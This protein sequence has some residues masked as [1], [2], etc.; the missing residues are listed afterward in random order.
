MYDEKDSHNDLNIH[1]VKMYDGNFTCGFGALLEQKT[2]IM[3]FNDN[4]FRNFDSQ[5][6]SILMWMFPKSGKSKKTQTIF[7]IIS[8]EDGFGNL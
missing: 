7:Q 5:T 6:F 1:N 8:L 4:I 3:V 2:S